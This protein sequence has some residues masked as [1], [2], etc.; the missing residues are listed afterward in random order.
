MYSRRSAASRSVHGTGKRI[1]DAHRGRELE[2]ARTFARPASGFG[3]RGGQAPTH[4]A[5][6]RLVV[7][8]AKKYV[9]RGMLFLDSS[10][11]QP[12][13]IVPSRSS[14]IARVQ[15]FDLR[16][17]VDPS[18]DYP[19][20]ADQRAR[21]ASRS[22]GRDDQSPHQDFASTAQELGREPRLKKIAKRWSDAREVREVMKISQ[23]DLAR[24]ADREEEDSH[25]GDFIEDK[26][27]SLR[28]AASVMLLKRR[29]RT[30]SKK[31]TIR[32]QV[33]V[34]RFGWKTASAT[35]E[36]AARIRRDGERI[37]QIEA[38]RS[39]ASHPRAANRSDTGQTIPRSV[40][41]ALLRSALPRAFSPGP[42]PHTAGVSPSKTIVTSVFA[43]FTP[44]APFQ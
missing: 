6:L 40:A 43:Y 7:S 44:W 4:E 27:R 2:Q 41:L 13:L 22:Y 26:R 12:R 11:G 17:V 37:R 28:E 14:I 30:C 42:S 8:I 35:L 33:L 25:L 5:N 16:H 34:L 9:G 10:R 29:C 19:A 32:T 36:E 39:Q 24:N 18:S 3:R 31:L 1:C 38:R 15:I 21:S 23:D 20:L